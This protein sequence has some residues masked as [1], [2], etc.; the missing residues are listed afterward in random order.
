MQWRRS[1]GEATTHDD[2]GTNERRLDE[3]KTTEED[4]IERK[5]NKAGRGSGGRG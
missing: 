4:R 1:D 2:E 3:T 5:K